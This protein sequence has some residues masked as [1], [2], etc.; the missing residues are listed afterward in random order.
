VCFHDAQCVL[1]T[2]AKFLVYLLGEGKLEGE[3]SEREM[4]R[5]GMVWRVRN[6]NARKVAPDSIYF[7]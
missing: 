4:E 3:S 5:K 1:S 7:A 6:E 2:I